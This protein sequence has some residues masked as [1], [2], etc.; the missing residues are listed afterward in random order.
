M[1]RNFYNLVALL[2]TVMLAGCNK[3]TE[4]QII[5]TPQPDSVMQAP[6][7]LFGKMDDGR[8]VMRYTLTNSHGMRMEVINYGGIVVRLEAPDKNGKL[9][10]VVLGFDSLSGYLQHNTFFGALVGRYGNRIAKGRF[11]LDEKEYKLAVNNDPNHLH[12]GVKG[13][14][15]VFW[16]IKPVKSNDGEALLLTYTSK[17]GEEGYPG[18][19]TVEVTYT[20]TADNTWKIDYKATTDK[21]TIINLTQHSYFNLTG[22]GNTDILKHEVMLN[23][24]KFIPVDKGLIPTGKLQDVEKTP[25]DF[26]TA[27]AV[28]AR[29][30]A[31][32]PQIAA[33]G[34]Y[35]HCWVLNGA[36]G[37]MR[38]V[39]TVYEPVSGRLLTVR[40]T[41][42]GVQF[43]SGNFLDG[44]AVGKGNV[45][46]AKRHGL[47]LETEHF[48]DSP[49]QTSFPS[50]V[51]E[52][53][54]V[55]ETTT[56]YTFGVK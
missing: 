13:F 26:R 20:L 14:D 23:A 27:T 31:K 28:G 35:D 24:D 54:K 41:E 18:T 42:P 52:P 29:I 48:P 4:T 55:Y 36:S 49:N 39:A 16:D 37:T 53:G 12:G 22:D 44:T 17:D 11:T 7:E 25:F 33:G 40:T 8:E 15:K 21:K 5:R 2:I 50:V 32:H 1:N 45:A 43:Y 56:T 9:A 10:D 51:L 19:L 47:C 46:Y 6:A 38:D 30:D 34:G 3:K